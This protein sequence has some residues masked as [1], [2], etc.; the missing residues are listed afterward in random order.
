M[1]HILSS[2]PQARPHRE[3]W[4]NNDLY[5][6]PELCISVASVA[7]YNARSLGRPR[8]RCLDLR[9]FAMSP[10]G[11]LQT[12]HSNSN[13]VS[14][15]NTQYLVGISRTLRCWCRCTGD[16]EPAGRLT[17]SLAALVTTRRINTLSKIVGAIQ[18]DDWLC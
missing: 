13:M 5:V 7:R 17:A 16:D 14:H 12:T 11:H 6:Q 2:R 4:P 1:I 9:S 18:H 15:Q 3:R 8:T 10:T